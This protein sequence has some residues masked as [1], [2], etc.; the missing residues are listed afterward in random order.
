ML[1]VHRVADRTGSYYLTDLAGELGVDVERR[2]GGAGDPGRDGR[3]VGTAAAR[4]DLRG[5]VAPGVFAA[6]VGGRHPTSGLTLPVR[7]TSVAAY[8]LTFSAPKSVSIL[9]A[10]GGPEMAEAVVGAHRAAVEVSIGYVERRAVA[11]RRGGDGR[12]N[13]VPARGLAAAAFDHGVS[14]TLEPHLHT[15]VVLTN[16][17]HG[18]DGRWSAIDGRGLFAHRAAAGSL[19][20]AH[21][22]VA[23]STVVGVRWA[24]RPDGRYEVAGVDPALRGEFSTRQADI[25]SHVAAR[26]GPSARSGRARRVAWAVTRPAKVPDLDRDTLVEGWRARAAGTG[27]V[28][29]LAAEVTGRCGPPDR[30]LDE[31]RYA[32]L[33]AVSPHAAATRRDVVRAW[34]ESARQGA[35][36]SDVERSA[37]WV[38][39]SP[40]QGVGVGEPLRTLAEVTVPAHLTR[41]L[42][43]RPLGASQQ[44]VWGDAARAIDGYRRRWGVTDRRAALGEEMEGPVRLPVR[45]LAE[46]VR[47]ARQIEEARAALGHERERA[48]EPPLRGIGR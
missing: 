33:L 40:P 32:S 17:A 26:P 22:R 1:H 46:H 12:R 45:R 8:D 47:V 6:L 43:P 5:R 25:L 35:A 48:A 27:V 13:V 36:G 30:W 16:A 41:A 29:D 39:G 34:A 3:W 9:F 14:R 42:G 7:R 15:H 10:L 23:L 2:R 31:H 19:Y 4:A 28:A 21:L 44:G 20:D 11:A 18:A 24:R 38:L 37:D